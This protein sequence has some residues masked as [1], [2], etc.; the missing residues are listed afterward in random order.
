VNETAAPGRR[1]LVVGIQTSVGR[2]LQR[3]T[4]AGF[5]GR[6]P[7]WRSMRLCSWDDPSAGLADRGADVAFLWLPVPAEADWVTDAYTANSGG[8]RCPR[9]ITSQTVRSSHGRS[10]SK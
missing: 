5:A 9:T 3:R 2:D 8:S 1:V 7:E 10:A 4:L 6:E